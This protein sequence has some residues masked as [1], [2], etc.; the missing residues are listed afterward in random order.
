VNRI[1]GASF[2]ADH[3]HFSADGI[4]GE[5]RLTGEWLNLP[6]SHEN[7]R[8]VLVALESNLEDFF[9]KLLSDQYTDLFDSLDQPMADGAGAP[10]ES[11][12]GERVIS[13]SQLQR[14][15]MIRSATACLRIRPTRNGGAREGFVPV[16][17][18]E[19]RIASNAALVRKEH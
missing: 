8:R 1:T 10:K 17:E 11:A 5:D 13:P 7:S 18:R 16:P 3:D 9:V 19:I 15:T 12:T 4:H 6:L 14:P 2:W